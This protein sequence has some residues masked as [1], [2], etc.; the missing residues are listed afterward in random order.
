MIHVCACECVHVRTLFH[1]FLSLSLSLSLSNKTFEIQSTN[2]QGSEI[3][4][5][6]TAPSDDDSR[7]CRTETFYELSLYS[8]FRK[9]LTFNGM[10]WEFNVLPM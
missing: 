3:G 8:A 2:G 7:R 4:D 9:G 6:S 5:V 1:F 10:A